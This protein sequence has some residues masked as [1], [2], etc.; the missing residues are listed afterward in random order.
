LKHISYQGWTQEKVKLHLENGYMPNLD[1][2][3]KSFDVNDTMEEIIL[4][5]GTALNAHTRDT[6]HAPC[7]IPRTVHRLIFNSEQSVEPRMLVVETNG[8]NY[9]AVDDIRSLA[10][11]CHSVAHRSKLDMKMGSNNLTIEK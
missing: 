2:K 4:I 10:N 7:I 1:D 6:I 11:S 3:T 5:Q 8:A 9:N